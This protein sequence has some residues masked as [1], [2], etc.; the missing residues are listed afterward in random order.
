[1]PN[2]EHL[3]ILK[4]SVTCWNNWRK[5]NPGVTP[6]LGSAYLRGMDLSFA[7]FR[8]TDLTDARLMNTNLFSACLN[9]ASLYKAN[10]YQASA[11]YAQMHRTNLS[12]AILTQTNLSR[13]VL[14][15]VN[16]AEAKMVE[17]DLS[18]AVLENARVYGISACNVEKTGLRQN[19]LIITPVGESE[20]SIDDIE[21]ATLIYNIYCMPSKMS[22]LLDTFMS[23]TVLIL[24]RFSPERMTVLQALKEELRRR[25]YLTL[26]FDFPGPGNCRKTEAIAIFAKLSKY[27]IAD[28]TDPSSVPDELRA[29]VPSSMSVPVVP[30]ILRGKPVYGLFDDWVGYPWMLPLYEYE[31]IFALRNDLERAVILPAE[32]MAA[33][34][35]KKIA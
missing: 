16:L 4:Q 17:T 34:L 8:D 3:A 29:I 6:D 26:I 1:M 18:H 9:G 15:E 33:Q 13:A 7:D 28:I 27:V 14:T 12:R 2:P 20:V 31:S 35:R 19:E 5:Q 30:I 32:Q 21:H 11:P 23:K 22:Q 24:G 25:N 10:L